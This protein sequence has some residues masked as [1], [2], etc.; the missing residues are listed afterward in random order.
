MQDNT[1]SSDSGTS[2]PKKQPHIICNTEP[3]YIESSME[4]KE[5]IEFSA[6]QKNTESLISESPSKSNKEFA[7][8]S[9]IPESSDSSEEDRKNIRN[10]LRLNRKSNTAVV[11][12]E[13]KQIAVSKT[14]SES[15]SSDLPSSSET[16]FDRREEKFQEH[17][18]TPK[19]HV[20][21]KQRKN[22]I[23]SDSDIDSPRSKCSGSKGSPRKEWVGPDPKVNL[24]DLGLNKKLGLWIE[25]ARKK[26]AMSLI[27]V[28]Y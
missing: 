27:P 13:G 16:S 2:P 19:K 18:R 22:D 21:N 4:E 12:N 6:L 3:Y 9:L 15:N 1:D 11:K 7:N 17:L 25:S 23:T 10:L 28:S 14:K 5:R 24:K 8:P 26:P 20:S